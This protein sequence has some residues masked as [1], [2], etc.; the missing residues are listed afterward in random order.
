[1]KLF[2]NESGF[3][4]PLALLVMVTTSAILVTAITTTS[5]T[6]RT[7]NIGKT[8]RQ[9][10]GAG[11]GRARQRGLDPRQARPEHE[12]PG[13]VPVHRGHRD[14]LH[15]GERHRQALGGLQHGDQHLDA[16]REGIDSEPDGRRAGHEDS[17]EDDP[18]ARHRGRFDGAG[19]EPLHPRRC[20]HLLHDRHRH[21]SRCRCFPGADV[22]QNGGNVAVNSTGAATT[23][24]VGTN[25]TVEGRGLLRAP[26]AS[27]HDHQHRVDERNRHLPGH[28]RHHLRDRLHPGEH[29][30]R[31]SRHDRVLRRDQHPDHRDHPRDPGRHRPKEEHPARRDENLYSSRP[32]SRPEQITGA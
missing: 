30:Q 5:S 29:G 2:R 6:G 10:R 16:V 26:G 17:L 25:L 32:V 20:E 14:Q 7:A 24:G 9:R 11:G 28:D 21:D 3:A 22:P 31:Q 1:M 18:G 8:A 4:L 19:V 27:H 23:V 15:D 13:A 12:H